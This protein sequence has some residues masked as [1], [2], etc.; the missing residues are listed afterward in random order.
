MIN[1]RLD[2][3]ISEMSSLLQSRGHRV[4]PI[5][6]SK[7]IDDDKLCDVFSHKLAGQLPV[8]SFGE[9]TQKASPQRPQR[10]AEK[11]H[12]GFKPLRFSGISAVKFKFFSI[13]CIH[14]LLGFENFL[15]KH[16]VADMY[17]R[18]PKTQRITKKILV[19]L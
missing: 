17:Y 12:R 8:T 9:L 10:N 14:S 6:A 1:N 18:G 11:K 16:V 7:R 13:Q 3:I 15:K 19:A 4:L 2:L 5:P